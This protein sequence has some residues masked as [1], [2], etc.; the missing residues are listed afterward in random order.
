MIRLGREPDA[1]LPPSINRQKRIK[2]C[3][4]AA[5]SDGA[6]WMFE[7]LRELRD[8][9]GYEVVAVVS[10]GQGRLIDKLRAENIPFHVSNFAAGPAPLR[11]AL[12]TP[13]AVFRM[14]RFFR[15]E[16][17]DVV[18]HHIF[19]SMRI[20]RPAAWL[21]DVPVRISMIAGPFHLQAQTSRWI[22]KFTY[23]MDTKLIP[24]CQASLT[25]CRELGIPER[26]LAPVVYYSPDPRNF[27]PAK[28]PSADIR[29]QFG[30][31]PD[32]PLVCMVAFFYPRLSTGAWVPEDV[33]GRG[34]KGHGDLVRAAPIILQEFP[35]TK[36]LL[37]GSGWGK[38]GEQYRDEIKDLVRR[39][40]LE[41]SVVFL[42][43]R[44]DANQILRTSDVAVQASL[45]ENLGGSLEALMMACPTVVTRV[46]GLIDSVRDGQ[47]GVV[48]NASDPKDLAR[49]IS[50]LLRDKEK[51][52]AL[53]KAGRQL[54]LDQFT[55]Q[56]TAEDLNSIYQDCLADNTRRRGSYNLLVSLWRYVVGTPLFAFMAFRLFFWDG[57]LF[58]KVRA[59][60]TSAPALSQKSFD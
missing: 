56:R 52:R 23:W 8:S 53:G 18:H 39:T 34:I 12:A 58:H 26:Y 14:A 5:T 6:T 33:K 49:G 30:W 32:T 4:V 42:G 37:V 20:A 50:E 60:L 28:V 2:I 27:D 9:H 40:K 11:E 21:A 36:F 29:G 59:W 31:P 25:L 46:G 55:L 13:L 15:R 17:F 10:D 35:N 1:L 48:V 54:M 24:S 3:H 45:N 16:R 57:Y 47:T 7:Q 44:E 19:I 22:E 38:A 43:F 51:A 41:S